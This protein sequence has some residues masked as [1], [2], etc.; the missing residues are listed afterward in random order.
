VAKT[1]LG[2]N[3]QGGGNLALR[4][5]VSDQTGGFTAFGIIDSLKLS[6]EN[7]ESEEADERGKQIDVLELLQKGMIEVMNKQSRKTDLDQILAGKDKYYSLFYGPVKLR[8]GNY[9]HIF[10]PLVKVSRNVT[11]NFGPETRKSS[12]KIFILSPLG[13]YTYPGSFPQYQDFDLS[14]VDNATELAAPTTNLPTTTANL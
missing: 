1:R 3:T 14:I 12:V 7:T 10:V 6:L 5:I 9:Q 8:D 11:M 4:E 13:T 2:L